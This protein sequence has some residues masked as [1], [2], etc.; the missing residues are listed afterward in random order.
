M[1][2]TRMSRGRAD[3]INYGAAIP[4]AGTSLEPALALLEYFIASSAQ[5]RWQAAC[6]EPAGD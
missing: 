5:A 2:T 6:P 3:Y 4:A 1:S